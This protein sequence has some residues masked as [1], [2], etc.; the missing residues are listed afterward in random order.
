MRLSSK[1]YLFLNKLGF[2]ILHIWIY[3]FIIYNAINIG[4]HGRKGRYSGQ[5]FGAEFWPVNLSLL[6]FALLVLILTL[7][8][9]KKFN[10][11]I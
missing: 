3:V 9:G 6:S 10:E 5:N 11:T 8:F 4:V 7:Y 1:Q 2:R